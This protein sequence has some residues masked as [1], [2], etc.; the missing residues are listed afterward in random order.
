MLL[1]CPGAT[2]GRHRRVLGR[3]DVDGLVPS[4]GCT[5]R[6]RTK[7]VVPARREVVDIASKSLEGRAEVKIRKSQRSE[8]YLPFKPI[9]TE[10]RNQQRAIR[11]G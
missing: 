9:R 7:D 10:A 1:V 4:T 3:E 8:T 2:R 11:F 6:C 5:W